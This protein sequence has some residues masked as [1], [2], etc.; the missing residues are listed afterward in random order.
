MFLICLI[1]LASACTAV[2]AETPGSQADET[3]AVQEAPVPSLTLNKSEMTIN[4][5]KTARLE[6]RLQN[7]KSATYTWVT[8]D[9][10]VATV[11][12][13]AVKG[14]GPGNAV[15]TC[16]AKL[17]DGSTLSAQAKVTVLVPVQ[18][19]SFNMPQDIVL[20]VGE[21]CRFIE[22]IEPDN[23]SDKSVEW[24]STNSAVATVDET[25]LV[26]AVGAG[27]T[28]IIATAKDGSRQKGQKQISVRSLLCNENIVFVTE[29]EGRSF[30]FDYF[31]KD[32]KGKVAVTAKGKNFSYTVTE[33]NG[34]VEVFLTPLAVG[35]GSLTF[36]DRMDPNSRITVIIR[37]T[38]D[39]IPLNQYLLFTDVTTRRDSMTLTVLNHSGM[40]LVSYDLRFIPYNKAG[41]QIFL[42]GGPGSE[43]RHYEFNG[44]F[45]S[46]K[47][48]MEKLVF[49][50]Y[51]GVDHM[52]IALVSVTPAGGSRIDLADNALYWYSTANKKYHEAPAVK[53][54]NCQPDSETAEKGDSFWLGYICS[55]VT[56]ELAE[57]YGY[58]HSGVC[59]TEVEKGS[60]AEQAGL[61]EKDLI[62]AA[63]GILLEADPCAVSKAKAK[64]SEGGSITLAVE[65]PGENGTVE[66]I[67]TSYL[68]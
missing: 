5:G 11:T 38:S 62:Y 65:R 57:H 47:T 66:I 45:S 6:H 63:D 43:I 1:F 37:V 31:G 24:S 26:T 42:P 35:K 23:A 2:S 41:E 58:S 18:S 49:S 27:K 52:E 59:V 46:G 7:A 8:S 48:K 64:I 56:P 55:E 29:P 16:T 22:K 61:R 28:T 44:R 53:A 67:I 50:P 68:K 34:K 9:P 39:A 25:G 51:E 60:L 19:I 40:D 36:S 54:V 4:R 14:I 13:G 30:T 32:W 12:Y 20:D 15:I 21:S 33:N 10:S 3:A 17:P